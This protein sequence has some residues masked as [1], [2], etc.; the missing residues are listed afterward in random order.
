[1]DCVNSNNTIKNNEKFLAFIKGYKTTIDESREKIFKKIKENLDNKKIKSENNFL[2]L[3]FFGL[4]FD[5]KK[6]TNLSSESNEVEK[7]IKSEKVGKKIKEVIDLT[8]DKVTLM[9]NYTSYNQITPLPLKNKF[10][11]KSSNRY[12]VKK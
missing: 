5:E 9:T 1:M 10:V 7:K 12:Y 6:D 8:D 2:Q 4:S 11:P 3:I